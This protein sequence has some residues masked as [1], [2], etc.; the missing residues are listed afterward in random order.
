MLIAKIL[1]SATTNNDPTN[2]L[3]DHSI[4]ITA[5]SEGTDEKERVNPTK[6]SI[7]DVNEFTLFRKRK[8]MIL[9]AERTSPR[10][11]PMRRGKF[12]PKGSS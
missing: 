5:V 12:D 10:W 8:L 7:N 1:G 4:G 6:T 11:T 3:Q 2:T 9:E